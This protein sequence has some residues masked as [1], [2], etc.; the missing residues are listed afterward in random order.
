MMRSRVFFSLA[1]LL[2]CALEVMFDFEHSCA[3][4]NMAQHKIF[5]LFLI[6]LITCIVFWSLCPIA[7]AALTESEALLKWKQSLPNYQP[8]LDS[9]VTPSQANSSEAQALCSWRGINCD[10]SGSIVELNLNSTGLEGTIGNLNFSALPNLLVLNLQY[11]KLSGSIPQSIGMLSRLQYLSLEGNNFSGSIPQS[12]GHCTNLS[13]LSMALNNLSGIIPPSFGRL[14]NLT[15]VRFHRNNLHGDLPQEFG[16][17]SSL[18]VV[19]LSYNNFTGHLPPQVCKGGK[20][21]NFTAA[22]NGLS[23]S[24]PPSLRN[25]SSLYRVQ[26][27]NN[28]LTGY[29]DQDFGAHPNLTYVDISFNRVQGNLSANWGACPSLEAL[30]MAGNSIGGNIPAEIF[31]LKKLQKLDLSSNQITGEIPPQIRNASMLYLLKLNRNNISG[32]MPTSFGSLSNLESLDLSMNRLSGSIP[33][34]IGNCYKLVNLNLSHNDFNGTIPYQIGNLDSLEDFLDL[35]FNSLSG[36]IPVDLIKLDNLISLNLSHN[37]LSGS[38]PDSLST[39]LSLSSINLSYNHLEGPAPN[40]GIFNSSYPLDLSNNKDLCGR[41]QGLRPCNVSISHMGST[42]EKVVISI[43][44]SLA[45][46]LLVTLVLVGIFFI[47]SKEN[48]GVLEQNSGTKKESPFSVCQFDGKDLYKD[49]VEATENFD[50][51][52]CVGEGSSGKVYKMV[53]QGGEQFAVKKFRC[54]ED[55]MDMESLKSFKSEIKALTEIRHR[56]IVKLYGFCS[57]G[58]HTFAVY[59]YMEGGTLADFLKNDTKALE[60]DWPKRVDVVKGV[61][62]ALSYMHHDCDPPIIH[63]DISSNNILLSAN[64]EAHVSDFGTARFLKASSS[65]IWTTFAGTRGYAAPGKQSAVIVIHS[66]LCQ[67]RSVHS[68]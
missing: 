41:I 34:Q 53:M 15:D 54:E 21:V 59:E 27:Q 60:L 30:I 38:I 31:Q 17:V 39:M 56:N 26:L 45:G 7:S 16:N 48:S 14:T 1:V 64:L 32:L 43:L 10:S 57:Q 29:A 47:C 13:V 22:Y 62:Q 20:L 8:I 42:K 61:A 6:P 11:N 51:K 33:Y 50:G 63:R 36:E 68:K 44:A 55:E 66:R 37:N 12:L 52:Y 35:S 58:S 23:G 46:A 67:M 28:R 2:I 49:I 25:C 40:S 9:W 3:F 19:H 5:P 18:I 65:S 4:T 24:I